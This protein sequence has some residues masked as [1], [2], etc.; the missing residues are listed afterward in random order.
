VS[1]R[2]GGGGGGGGVGGSFGTVKPAGAD[3]AVSVVVESNLRLESDADKNDVVFDE[4]TGGGGG[5]AAGAIARASGGR[6]AASCDGRK[7][8]PD[9]TDNNS[10]DPGAGGAGASIRAGASAEAGR[11]VGSSWFGES[12]RAGVSPI[13]ADGSVEAANAV[14]AGGTGGCVKTVDSIRAGAESL[15]RRRRES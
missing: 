12:G 7:Y 11:S 6:C 13:G 8:V 1:E 15:C 10:T 3:A 9:S 4:C 2:G 14:N 5:I